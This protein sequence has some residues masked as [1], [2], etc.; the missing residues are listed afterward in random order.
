MWKLIT[1]ETIQTYNTTVTIPTLTIFRQIDI[2]LNTPVY[3]D[4][5]SYAQF[6]SEGFALGIYYTSLNNFTRVVTLRKKSIVS[7]TFLL[8]RLLA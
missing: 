6:D 2:C 3:L 5:A 7:Q 4:M 8:Q 1:Y